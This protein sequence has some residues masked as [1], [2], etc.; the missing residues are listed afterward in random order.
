[1][2]AT[3]K[4]VTWTEDKKAYDRMVGLGVVLYLGTFLGLGFALFPQTTTET[5]II[6]ALGTCA[7]LLLHLVLSIG[8]LARLDRRFLPLLYNRRHLGVVTF[9]LGA[10]HGLFALVQFHGLGVRNPL[11]SV[12]TSNGG[13]DSVA[14]FPFQPLGLLALFILFLMAATSHDFWLANL[15]APTWKA[16]HMAVYLAYVA[17][18]GH[19]AL[20]ALQSERH[21]LLAITLM[22]GATWVTG[23]H[24]A[25][26]FFDPI[27]SRVLEPEQESDWIHV[28]PASDIPL[29][30]ARLVEVGGERVAVFRYT[31]DDDELV[32]AVS[33]VCQ[34]QNGPLGEGKIIDGCITCPWHGFQYR[35]ED[36]SSPPPFTE[37][38]P[39]FAVEIRDGDVWLD[40][41]PR[42][43]GTRL[44]PAR[45]GPATAR[46]PARQSA[47]APA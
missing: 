2:S 3:Y 44:E 38:I 27:D 33:S 17:L 1:M 7:F 41:K 26:A 18:V 12:L 37:K 36:G 24:L 32:S 10:A 20:G 4:A 14:Q 15:T 5:Q 43:A 39:T 35:P 42:P 13:Y 40:P 9:L 25:A 8:P 6:R 31:R 22:V 30:R 28:G 45:V 46:D 11:V 23:L 16:L 47:G 21:P 34:H 29:Q 19:V